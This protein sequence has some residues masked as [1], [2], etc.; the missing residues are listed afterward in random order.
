MLKRV[1]DAFNCILLQVAEQLINPF[2]EDDDD[3][4]I[5]WLIDRH[6]AVRITIQLNL[7]I[8]TPDKSLHWITRNKQ[9]GSFVVAY[10]L[11]FILDNSNTWL[12]QSDLQLQNNEIHSTCHIIYNNVFNCFFNNLKLHKDRSSSFPRI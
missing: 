12:Y 4:D 2:G 6:S 1:F 5:N 11:Y 9:I 3:F 10:C 7:V 8:S